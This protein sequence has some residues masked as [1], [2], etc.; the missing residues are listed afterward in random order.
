MRKIT[1]AVV[2]FAVLSTLSGC[3][4]AFASNQGRRHAARRTDRYI[5]QYAEP[6]FHDGSPESQAQMRQA[7]NDIADTIV[8]TGND[9]YQ[10]RVGVDDRGWLTNER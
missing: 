7:R 8:R 6:A 4:G 10:N 3:L 2:C 1:V 9:R 5:K